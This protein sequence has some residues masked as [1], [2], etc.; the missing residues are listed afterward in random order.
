MQLKINCFELYQLLDAFSLCFVRIQLYAIIEDK[1][2][3]KKEGPRSFGNN[4]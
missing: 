4:S 2:P 3:L 1:Q